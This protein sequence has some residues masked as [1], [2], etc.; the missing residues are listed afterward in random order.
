VLF[1]QFFGV[2]IVILVV[3]V[4]LVAFY[5]WFTSREVF[6]RQW[7]HELETQAR[8]A[9]V[10]LPR[11]DGSVDDAAIGRFFE[12]LGH[13][14]EH[15]FT[16][17]LPD[18]RVLGDSEAEAAHMDSHK[19]RP[20]VIEAMAHGEGMSQRY[21]ATVG[22]QMLYLA[23]RVPREGPIQAI[24]RVS[25]PLRTLTREM[26]TSNGSWWFCS[27]SFWA[28]RWRSATAP[29]CASWGLFPS[30]RAASRASAAASC[31]SGWRSRRC[32]TSPN[33]P[34]RSTRRSIGCRSISRL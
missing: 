6:H 9:A 11:G 18:G 25:V 12:R 24:V 8:L 1:W 21:S 30:C 10:L 14:G 17:I 32:R 29:R 15:R 16:L 2:H 7:V 19:D 4:G 34:A 13:L 3:A 5:T 23:E 20:E 26:D 33:W 28:P 22:K 31:L 27:S